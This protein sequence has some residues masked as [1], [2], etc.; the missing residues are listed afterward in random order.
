M[1]EVGEVINPE[2]WGLRVQ[3]TS[4]EPLVAVVVKNTEPTSYV[5]TFFPVGKQLR[6]VRTQPDATS[7]R[8]D[9][10]VKDMP[11]Y[12]LGIYEGRKRFEHYR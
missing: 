6:F 1:F 9:T 2:D 4:I 5:G 7:W 10:D 11:W 8:I 3:I 12:I